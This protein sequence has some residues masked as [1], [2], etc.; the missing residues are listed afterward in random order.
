MYSSHLWEKILKKKKKKS[1]SIYFLK[2]FLLFIEWHPYIIFFKYLD[3]Q[4]TF[5]HLAFKLEKN[6]SC[7]GSMNLANYCNE[8]VIISKF[9]A[10]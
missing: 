7:E 9:A 2:R 1:I 4:F 5:N 6:R 8:F 3:K 10:L